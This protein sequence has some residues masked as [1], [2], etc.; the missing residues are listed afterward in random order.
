[1]MPLE[2]PVVSSIITGASTTGS[3][4]L[5][6]NAVDAAPVSAAART[7]FF[8]LTSRYLRGSNFRTAHPRL[9]SY[10]LLISN[11]VRMQTVVVRKNTLHAEMSSN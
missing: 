8:I 5:P 7:S 3:D 2:E 11:D 9:T 1:M 10:F 4:R 6:A